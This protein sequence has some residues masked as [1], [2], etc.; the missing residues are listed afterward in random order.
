[1]YSIIKAITSAFYDLLQIKIIWI[2]IWPFLVAV[3]FWLIIG[4]VF[5]DSFSIWISQGFVEIGLGEWLESVKPAWLAAG[6][7]NFI[8]L[9]VFVPLVMVTTLI[10]TAVFVMP[11]LINLVANRYYPNLKRESGGS[12]GG[13]LAN[14]LLAIGIFIVICVVTIP[15]WAFGIGFIFPFIAAAYMNQQLFRYDAIS[16][17]ANKNEI[18][19]LLTSNRAS[20]WLLGLLTGFLQFLPFINFFAP[21]ITALAFIH[22]ELARLKKIRI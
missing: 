16:E 13:S 4:G 15:L 18:K 8:H 19:R 6:I 5:W 11:A 2:M 22:Y 1:M 21:I 7:Q 3:L 20:L 10:I 17:H 14:A 12:I 9:V